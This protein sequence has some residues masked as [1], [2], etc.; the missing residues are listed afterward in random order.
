MRQIAFIF[1]TVITL[2]NAF[3]QT[4]KHGNPIFNNEPISEEQLEGFELT[5]SYYTIDNNISNKGSSVY[6][7]D[8]PTLTDYL[9]FARDLPSYFFI[10]HQGQ[11]VMVMISLIQKNDDTN[12]TLS[13]NI[14]NPNNGKSMQAP[15]SVFGEISEKR[16][17]ELLKLKVDTASKI[18]DL[19]T[20]N[21]RGLLFDG[22]IYR[23]Q[24]YDKLK[25]EVIAIAK[26]LLSPEEEIKDPVEYIK[27]ETTGGKLDFNK[28]LEAENQSFFL[29]D[30][31]MYSKKDFAIYLWGRKVKML[32]I[33]SSK[34]AVKLWEGIN[35]R[36]LTGPE[37]KH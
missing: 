10:V 36:T 5:S 23:I 17:D 21:G 15:C 25:A 20:N 7:S 24:P 33:S 13:Y 34:E 11:R 35:N 22:I 37:K 8:N 30:G 16:A 27:K 29:Y 1:L 31:V 28:V 4:D 26:Q 3:G 12:T 14:V 6:V 19:P 2:T 32:G 18:I 9:N